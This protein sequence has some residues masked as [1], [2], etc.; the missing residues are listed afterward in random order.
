MLK[1]RDEGK[2]LELR[3]KG[4]KIPVPDD[5][6]AQCRQY[7]ID[8][9][10]ESFCEKA[11]FGM[12]EKVSKKLTDALNESNEFQYATA[13]TVLKKYGV[14]YSDQTYHIYGGNLAWYDSKDKVL[15]INIPINVE[16]LK[17]IKHEVIHALF[18][19]LPKKEQKR[20]YR[21][22]AE[23]RK[24]ISDA[25]AFFSSEELE[26]VR[27]N[28][29]LHQGILN[30]VRMND[31][32]AIAYSVT[33]PGFMELLRDIEKGMVNI[34]DSGEGDTNRFFVS[35]HKNALP[36]FDFNSIL[37]EIFTHYEILAT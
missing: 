23:E 12:S 26:F 36:S 8:E 6:E 15:H 29:R 30:E 31:D 25:L 24:K 35:L 10:Y 7:G 17:Y 5:W 14:Y 19:N 2:I 16:S 33:E 21:K 27:R 20:L 11:L 18:Y 9:S 34:S 37:A 28:Y 13:I 4:T 32:E 22:V 3:Q 1:L